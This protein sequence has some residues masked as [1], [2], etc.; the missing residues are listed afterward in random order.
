MKVREKI[1]TAV[2]PAG[3]RSV[4]VRSVASY[5]FSNIIGGATM[6]D[7]FGFIET[8]ARTNSTISLTAKS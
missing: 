5:Q 2:Y 7:V 4:E 1:R 3:E 8:V 6:L